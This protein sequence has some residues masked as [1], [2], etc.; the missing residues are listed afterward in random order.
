MKKLVVLLLAFA[1]AGAAFAQTP[2]LS[3]SSTLSWGVDLD[4]GYTGFLNSSSVTFSVPFTF[5]GATSKKGDTGWWGEIAVK[6]LY[7]KISDAQLTGND[8][9]LVDWNDKD[10]DGA[11]DDGEIATL[12]AFITNGAWKMSVSSK[13]SFDFANADALDDGDVV[14][15]LDADKYGTTVSYSA[16]GLSFG[17]TAASKDDWTLNTLNE[18]SFGANVQVVVDALT[19]KGQVA[20]DLLDADK[21]LGFTA[22]AVYAADP[23]TVSLTS[24][25][26][27]LGGFDADALLDVQFAV[28]EGLDAYAD[29]Y[30]STLDNDVEFLVGADY[31]KDA[32]EAGVAFGLYDPLT[33]MSYYFDVYA[34]YTLAVANATELYVYADYS[35][36]FTGTG[37]LVPMVTLTN[38][39]IAN[40]TLTLKYNS[41]ELDVLAGTYGTLIAAAKISL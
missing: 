21:E 32:L 30:F 19:V 31:A 3:A 13:S 27:V 6:N 40:T 23:L 36:D 28:M 9:A 17:V 37:S 16:D 38:K 26:L 18:Y 41:G 34:G 20:Y 4:T 5:T 25:M 24:D 39:S 7:L 10:G 29:A 11:I 35:S 14:V 33:V 12:T 22:G 1:V 8:A 15:A 2:A